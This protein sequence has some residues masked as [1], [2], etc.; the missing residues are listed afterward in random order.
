MKKILRILL[1]L[2]IVIVAV[3]GVGVALLAFFASKEL[4][5]RFEAKLTMKNPV[6]IDSEA[7]NLSLIHALDS[8]IYQLSELQKPITII[9]FGEVDCRP[10]V[11]ELPVIE[12]FNEK[13]SD[14]YEVVLISRRKHEQSRKFI[15]KKQHKLDFYFP[16]S[17]L[18]EVFD[19]KGTPRI[20][21]LSGNKIY[22][23]H[24]G[25]FDWSNEKFNDFLIRIFEDRMTVSHN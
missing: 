21:V 13:Y 15:Q 23:E 19:K 5:E 24:V 12:E 11:K 2:V 17:E 3:I 14:V 18:P 7:Y 20:L 6:A 4:R 1:K 9:N 16:V 8:N 10:C 25:K 22:L